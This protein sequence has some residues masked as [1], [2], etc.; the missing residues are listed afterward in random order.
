MHA[1]VVINLVWTQNCC[2]KIRNNEPRNQMYIIISKTRIQN[3]WQFRLCSHRM[4]QH[5]NKLYKQKWFGMI[6]CRKQGQ[7]WQEH[8]PKVRNDIVC[9]EDAKYSVGQLASQDV[10]HPHVL[11]PRGNVGHC[12]EIHKLI[13]QIAFLSLWTNSKLGNLKT[14]NCTPAR[15][16]VEISSHQHRNIC[17]GCY[18]FESLQ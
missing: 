5:L 1:T 6:L 16:G 7:T 15:Y 10:Q 9:S 3:D 17:T 13:S 8:S 18:F 11:L 4:T 14:L 2:R 12:H